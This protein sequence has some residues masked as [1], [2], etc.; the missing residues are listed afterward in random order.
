VYAAVELMETMPITFINVSGRSTEEIFALARRWVVQ[1]VGLDSFGNANDA[2]MIYD[3]IQTTSASDIGK[4]QQEYQTLGFL[5]K[6]IHNFVVEHDISCMAFVQL[7]RSGISVDDL[8]AVSGSDRISQI[9][10]SVSFFKEKGE[11]EVA[12]DGK[13]NGNRRINIAKARHGAGLPN[14]Y[15][16]LQ[17]HG[18]ISKIVEIGTRNS[19]SRTKKGNEFETQP[20]QRE[21]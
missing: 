7:N 20:E 9:G 17:L 19:I 3:Y 14:D 13:D 2:L 15:I 8:S 11:E 16:N 6:A 4:D 1:K 18:G 10:T 21:F 5:T 12:Q